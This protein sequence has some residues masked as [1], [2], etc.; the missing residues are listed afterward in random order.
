MGAPWLQG[1][2]GPEGW[3]AERPAAVLGLCE[4]PLPV[5]LRGAELGAGF[6]TVPCPQLGAAASA[7]PAAEIRGVTPTEAP[8]CPSG[9][10]RSPD[11]VWHRL[12]MN[13][14]GYNRLQVARVVCRH[15]VFAAG[16]AVLG[17]LS[18]LGGHA[19][20]P[21]PYVESGHTYPSCLMFILLIPNNL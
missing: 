16:V 10:A 18:A 20:H 4:Q 19:V 1:D 9:R 5:L 12:L 3:G 15:G 14:G 11:S 21:S 13:S 7:H 8:L 6:G 2:E 17:P